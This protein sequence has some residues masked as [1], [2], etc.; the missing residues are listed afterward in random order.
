MIESLTQLLNGWVYGAFGAE[1]PVAFQEHPL[2]YSLGAAGMAVA[3]ALL[4]LAWAWFRTRA[5]LTA[6]ARWGGL[7]R[8]R[9]GRQALRH[10]A[11]IRA[12]AKRL[13]R[14]IAR[15]VHDPTE[16]RDL[17]RVLDRF[18]RAELADTLDALRGWVALGGAIQV[19]ALQR[20]LDTQT[21][22]WSG[23]PDG[24]ER[25][26]AERDVAHIRQQLALAQRATADHQRLLSGLEEAAAAIRTLEA[27]LLAL[28]AT[29]SPALPQFSAHL[30]DLAEDFRRQREVYLEFQPH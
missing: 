24:E 26:R 18:V 14:A 5:L 17:W 11:D 15:S 1:G 23:L 22:Y 20:R 8:S 2:A 3:A 19:K 6:S 13:R 9:A 16:R 7:M 4:A 21:V 25:K 27:E 30:D 28:G 10:A 29:R 12:G